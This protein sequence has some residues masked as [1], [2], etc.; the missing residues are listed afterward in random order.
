[1]ETFVSQIGR[2]KEGVHDGV[3]QHISVAVAGKPLAMGD[4]H[5]AQHQLSPFS[6]RMGVEADS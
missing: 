1:M 2:T 4:G 6:Q 3:D 5:A